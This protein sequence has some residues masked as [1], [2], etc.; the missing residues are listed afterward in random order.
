MWVWEHFAKCWRGEETLGTTFLAT[1][2]VYFGVYAPLYF[3]TNL[4]ERTGLV[5]ACQSPG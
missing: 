2:L 1:V 5:G 3:L 4:A